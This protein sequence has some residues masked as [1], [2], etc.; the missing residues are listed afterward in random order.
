MTPKTIAMLTDIYNMLWNRVTTDPCYDDIAWFGVP[1]VNSHDVITALRACNMKVEIV[2]LRTNL[3]TGETNVFF[4][5][6]EW[7]D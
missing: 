7:D 3:R 1:S 5:L 4:A 6:T 2:E